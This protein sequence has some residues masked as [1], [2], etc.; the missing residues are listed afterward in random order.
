MFCVATDIH[1]FIWTVCQCADAM[2]KKTLLGH[3]DGAR[4]E[5]NGSLVIGTLT[6]FYRFVSFCDLIAS[7]CNICAL[8]GTLENKLYRKTIR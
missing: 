8:N 7:V 4:I 3:S 1:L 5:E 2:M 6:T